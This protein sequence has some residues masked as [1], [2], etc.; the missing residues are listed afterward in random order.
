M[1]LLGSYARCSISIA[2]CTA[3]ARAPELAEPAPVEAAPVREGRASP[4]SGASSAAPPAA[5]PLAAA[6]RAWRGVASSACAPCG[7]CRGAGARAGSCATSCEGVH[8][9]EHARVRT[10]AGAGVGAALLNSDLR[11][12]WASPA[13]L[14]SGSKPTAPRPPKRVRVRVA[15][16][17]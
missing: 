13:A 17:G 9:G 3:S 8:A 10:D 2:T 1:G 12:V 14:P 7:A 15:A 5:A 4:E 11:G 16:G 6:P